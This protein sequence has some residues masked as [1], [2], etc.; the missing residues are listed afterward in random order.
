MRRLNVKKAKT[1]PTDRS[2]IMR[3][4]RSRDTKPELIVRKLAWRI[5]PGYRLH[6]KDI[7]GN[8]DIAYVGR[9]QAIFVHGCFWHGHDCPLFKWPG[10][11]PDFWRDKIGQN[12]ANDHKAREALLASEWRVAIVWE[13]A[14][15]GASK[16][17]KAV[18]HSLADWL[19][20]CA[21]FIEERG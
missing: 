16:N 2:A 17:T 13:C 19:Q 5:R 8:P 18:A 15:R 12:R 10:T 1:T 9:K 14:I 21:P 4:V 6:R 7:P 20:G 11:R 3:A